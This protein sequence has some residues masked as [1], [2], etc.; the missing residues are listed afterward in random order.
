ML[1]S[2]IALHAM[3]TARQGDRRRAGHGAC[4]VDDKS[5]ICHIILVHE[6]RL[7]VSGDEPTVQPQSRGQ[8]TKECGIGTNTAL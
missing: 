1:R 7:R 4:R 2:T 5:R 3:T 8:A 6:F